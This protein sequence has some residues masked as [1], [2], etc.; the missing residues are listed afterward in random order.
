[1]P[2]SAIKYD[3]PQGQLNIARI[4]AYMK[5]HREKGVSQAEIC[6]HM[7]MKRPTISGYMVHL[8]R[9]EQVH[10]AIK[11]QPSNR[12]PGTGS[13]A[14]YK[15]GPDPTP[16]PPPR[17]AKMYTDLPLNFFRSSK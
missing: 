15:L 5:R 16:K 11:M 9:T 7:C 8:E 3:S 1:M 17:P 12:K 13:P 6:F 10:V 2:R 14:V 4:L